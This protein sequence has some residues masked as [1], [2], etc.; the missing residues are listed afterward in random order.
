MQLD[1]PQFLF[2]S[3][4]P[5]HAPPSASKVQDPTRH[6]LAKSPLKQIV[7]ELGRFGVGLFKA[8]PDDAF[9]QLLGRI[10]EGK[11]IYVGKRRHLGE[12]HDVLA[13]YEKWP[14]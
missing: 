5:E 13:C 9:L 3:E 7:D 8:L 6:F 11:L 14:R 10:G 12:S 2:E 4:H 1:I